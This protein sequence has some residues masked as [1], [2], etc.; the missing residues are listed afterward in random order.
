[1]ANPN[2][3]PD[4]LERVSIATNPMQ[5][6]GQGWGW[7]G[8]LPISHAIIDLWKAN[9]L[10]VE[11][12][13]GFR[14]SE[15]GNAVLAGRIKTSD[16]IFPARVVERASVTLELVE[17]GDPVD[18]AAVGANPAARPTKAERE[19]L[20]A[21]TWSGED[22]LLFVDGTCVLCSRKMQIFGQISHAKSA[23]IAKGDPVEIET[24]HGK[25]W[26]VVRGGATRPPVEA[27]VAPAKAPAPAKAEP[28]ECAVC[29]KTLDARYT[30]QMAQDAGWVVLGSGALCPAHKP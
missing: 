13:G 30:E 7:L 24:R 2:I 1:M 21:G 20:R 12:E 29:E 16:L 14:P 6:N 17:D 15:R 27:P 18:P 10:L 19:T 3:Y 23:H 25:K 4:L 26:A 9:D 22:T 28:I 8:N 11:V 5:I